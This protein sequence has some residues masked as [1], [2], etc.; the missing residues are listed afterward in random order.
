MGHQ[1]K[2][3][4]CIGDLLS[5]MVVSGVITYLTQPLADRVNTCTI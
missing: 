1:A 3:V 2:A 4:V 5:G